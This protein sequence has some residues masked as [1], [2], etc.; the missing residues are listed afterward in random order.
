[1]RECA[2]AVYLHVQLVPAWLTLN[3]SHTILKRVQ[4]I[5]MHFPKGKKRRTILISSLCY[6]GLCAFLEFHY[7]INRERLTD[8]F[9]QM[10]ILC[11]CRLIIHETCCMQSGGAVCEK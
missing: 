6:I 1:M 10:A 3:A 2:I 8:F 5:F 9:P 7:A 4:R 11:K